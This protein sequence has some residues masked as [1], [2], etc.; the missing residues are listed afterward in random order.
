LGVDRLQTI[1]RRFTDDARSNMAVVIPAEEVD[2]LVFASIPPSTATKALTIVAI[3]GALVLKTNDNA[4]PDE[5]INLVDGAPLEWTS[6]DDP[7]V[8]PFPFGQLVTQ[9]YVD[10][11][12]L[13]DVELRIDLVFD[14]LDPAA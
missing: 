3:G 14:P 4:T 1:E 12:G 11:E 8:K 5:T 2:R 6:D 10:N 13:A 9:I 7:A